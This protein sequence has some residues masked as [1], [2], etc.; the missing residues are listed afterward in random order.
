[1]T[2][3]IIGA[4]LFVLV[5]IARVVWIVKY[6]MTLL[7]VMLFSQAGLCSLLLIFRSPA[8]DTAPWW[9]KTGAWVSASLP[10]VF[11]A[12]ATG[13]FCWGLLPVPGLAL[14][15]W[16][17]ITLGTA[18]GISPAYRGLVAKGPYRWLR[19]PMYAGELLSLA[20]GM[21]GAFNLWNLLVIMLFAASLV[22]RIS[23]EEGIL[24]RNG[25]LVYSMQVHWRL[26]PG[27]W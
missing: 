10:L 6:G 15:L 20:G 5:A 14:N 2:L 16:A 24:N 11:F 1:M 25:Y 17:L 18:F 12:P 7:S 13:S 8:N 23:W 19:H 21:I 22:W 4:F 9:V 27:I 3:S 26:A